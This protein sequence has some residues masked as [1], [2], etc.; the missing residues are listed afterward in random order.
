MWNRYAGRTTADR[1]LL[2]TP[3]STIY[4]NSSCSKIHNN[5]TYA[6]YKFLSLC[7]VS[8]GTRNDC[9]NKNKT[10]KLNS[11]NFFLL[12]LSMHYINVALLPPFWLLC[13]TQRNA[14]NVRRERFERARSPRSFCSWVEF[15]IAS[16]SVPFSSTNSFAGCHVASSFSSP[17]IAVSHRRPYPAFSSANVILFM[18]SS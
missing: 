4:Q 17:F 12:F 13:Y 3:S 11:S 10:S 5:Y 18:E 2:D 15:W 7:H 16:V 1:F 14:N 6:F 9:H 8:I